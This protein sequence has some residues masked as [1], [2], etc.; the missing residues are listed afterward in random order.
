MREAAKEFDYFLLEKQKELNKK[1]AK[2]ESHFAPFFEV[3]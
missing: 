2:L 3:I 1:G